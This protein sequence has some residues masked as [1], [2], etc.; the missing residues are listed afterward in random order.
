[1]CVTCVLAN[2]SR[3][4][5]LVV[6]TLRGLSDAIA[7]SRCVCLVP[8]VQVYIHSTGEAA[9]EVHYQL[10]HLA[11]AHRGVVVIDKAAR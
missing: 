1:M 8:D 4:S 5:M 3:S 7:V 11:D 10:R 2:Q 6:R 9:V